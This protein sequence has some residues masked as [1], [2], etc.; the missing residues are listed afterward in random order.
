MFKVVCIVVL[1]K[2]IMTSNIFLWF[3]SWIISW[4]IRVYKVTSAWKICV[5]TF[6]AKILR[7]SMLAKGEHLKHLTT[8]KSDFALHS[9]HNTIYFWYTELC[10]YKSCKRGTFAHNSWHSPIL[11][12]FYRKMNKTVKSIWIVQIYWTVSVF[13]CNSLTLLVKSCFKFARAPLN[14]CR[15]YEP[16]SS[17]GVPGWW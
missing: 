7:Q 6:Q 11:L 8:G 15:G 1:L 14:K 17:Q 12:S 3:A 9:Q 10:L 5:L 16:I 2:S 13:F 4:V